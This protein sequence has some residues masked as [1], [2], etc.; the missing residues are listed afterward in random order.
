M[1]SDIIHGDIKPLNALVFEHEGK[2]IVKLADFGDASICDN[3]ESLTLL[4]KSIP[5]SAPEHHIRGI[6]FLKATKMDIYSFGMLC[7]WSLFGDRLSLVPMDPIPSQFDI[8][9]TEGLSSTVATLAILKRAKVIQNVAK[10]CVLACKGIAAKQQAD[11][12]TLFTLTLA[13]DPIIRSNDFQTMMKLLNDD[14]SAAFDPPPQYLE[15]ESGR[16]K[17]VDP[18]TRPPLNN[19][20]KKHW[21][22][23]IRQLTTRDQ[24]EGFHP[25][26]K[27]GLLD[28]DRS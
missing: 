17:S 14:R 26:F 7:L 20:I 3:D 24:W 10:E 27:V 21:A 28:F 5:W 8:R 18:L 22:P 16:W 11:L 1:L 6:S 4:P 15:M 25:A 12:N 9:F 23:S 19:P 2:R 13:D